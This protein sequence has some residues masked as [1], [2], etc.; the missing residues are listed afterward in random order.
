MRCFSLEKPELRRDE[1]GRDV[2]G[3]KKCLKSAINVGDE[4]GGRQGG[5]G[6]LGSRQ[7]ILLK[8]VKESTVEQIILTAD[9]K[10]H[11]GADF[12]AAAHDEDAM[13]PFTTPGNKGKDIEKLGLKDRSCD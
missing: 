1:A 11:V 13:P 9:G 6:A 2:K 10:D 8:I 4:G 5:G 12:C 7:E 3:E